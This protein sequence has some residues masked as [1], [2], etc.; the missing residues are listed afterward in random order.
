MCQEE[1]KKELNPKPRRRE[2]CSII[3]WCRCAQGTKERNLDIVVT[4]I[5][6]SM[7]GKLCGAQE[8]QKCYIIIYFYGLAKRFIGTISLI[9]FPLLV[10]EWVGPACHSCRTD[11]WQEMAF[12]SW[13][14]SSRTL[15]RV[16]WDGEVKV[17]DCCCFIVLSGRCLYLN[18]F[19][20]W[21]CV[22]RWLQEW[23]VVAMWLQVESLPINSWQAKE[24]H[25]VKMIGSI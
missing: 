16:G 19:G 24:Y 1:R 10:G 3:C 8:W 17:A 2:E 25:N 21:T 4:I 9:D 20:R 13:S 6:G 22:Y 18:G 12:N 15:L 14:S 23:F 5:S 11:R 7:D